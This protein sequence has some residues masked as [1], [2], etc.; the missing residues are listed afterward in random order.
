VEGEW[1]VPR[2]AAAAAAP[3]PVFRLTP[4]AATPIT[5]RCGPLMQG[6]GG[7][8]YRTLTDRWW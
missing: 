3:Y 4:A 2:A 7:G 8:W 6:E 1:A 5:V